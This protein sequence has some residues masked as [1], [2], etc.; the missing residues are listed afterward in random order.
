MKRITVALP[1]TL[2]E[3]IEIPCS[4]FHR[5]KAHIRRQE[6][7]QGRCKPWGGCGRAL[8][9]NQD[10]FRLFGEDPLPVHNSM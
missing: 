2:A 5:Q 4:Q 8:N 6:S 3:G 10:T 9:L 7:V 1:P